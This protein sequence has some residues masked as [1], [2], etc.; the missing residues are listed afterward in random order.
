MSEVEMLQRRLRRTE[1][2]VRWLMAF[3]LVLGTALL[4]GAAQANRANHD[5]L[6]ARGLVIT[7]AAGNERIVI[8]APMGNASSNAQLADGVGIAVLDSSRRLHVAVGANNPLVLEDG[9]VGTRIAMSAGLTIYDPRDGR[10]RGGMGAFADGRANI[11]LDY[12]TATKEAACLAVAPNDDYAAV[13]LN[14]TPEEEVF[15]RAVM[16]V[17]ADGGGSIK[18]FGGR[19][20]RGGIMMRAGKG[21]ASVTVYDSSGVAVGDLVRW[22]DGDGR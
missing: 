8:G 16:F 1:R 13:I 20:N 21:P 12:G 18:V 9:T 6:T 4:I 14:G 7:D 3:C 11:C 2:R 10:E 5:V 19:E 15:D 22:A 17:G